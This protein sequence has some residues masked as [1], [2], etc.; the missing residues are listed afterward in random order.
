MKKL[1]YA[2]LVLAAPVLAQ[3]TVNPLPSREFGQPTLI[4]PNT[5]A[6]SPN[7]VVGQELY[8]P[9]AIAFDTSVTPPRVYVVD[10]GNN[11]VLGWSN[12]NNVSQGTF[13]DL[14]L[15]QPASASGGFDLTATLPWGPGTSNPE[16]L[17]TP[18]GVAVDAAGNVYVS[19]SANNR[20]LRFA[21]PYKQQPGNLI[22]DLVIGQKTISGDQANQGNQN[23]SSTTL[24]LGIAN[25]QGA[26][27]A[28]LA[29][30]GSG[31]LWARTL[32]ISG[33]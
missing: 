30:D 22:V 18:T 7:L 9:S 28:G 24:Y 31:N 12:A 20:I 6:S 8:N 13:A 5:N 23:P 16:G 25:S 19:D 21:T 27:P 17:N 4:N 29:V 15:G 3:L 33:C 11:R 1:V 26:I 32:A 10:T 2:I 14:V